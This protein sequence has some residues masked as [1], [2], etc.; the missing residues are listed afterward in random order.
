[1]VATPN[2]VEKYLE[3]WR[4]QGNESS[5]AALRLLFKTMPKNVGPGQ[6]AVK[7]AALNGLYATSIYGVVQMARH[8]VELDIDDALAVEV[9]D[10]DL[11]DKIAHLTLQAKT[12]RS[13]LL[14]DEALL[15]PLPRHPPHLRLARRRSPQRPT[16]S[17]REFDTFA[18]REH[19]RT[20]YDVYCRSIEGFRSHFGLEDL[21][22]R[23]IDKYLWM[24]A[25]ERRGWGA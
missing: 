15:V 13:L 5:D 17:G 9:A 14:R 1:M 25:K 4:A 19:W 11:V 8:I 22:I 12:R 3:K 16:E 20:D 21:S 23:D 24:L 10:P 18:P 7:V 2:Q 6:V